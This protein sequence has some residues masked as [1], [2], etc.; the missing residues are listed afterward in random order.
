MRNTVKAACA[1]IAA[2]TLSSTNSADAADLLKVKMSRLAFPSLSTMMIDIV[3][4][5]GIDKRH[6]I[7]LE[8][9]TF[10]GISG[11]YG[12]LANGDADMTASGPLVVQ[13]MILE[14]VPIRIGMTWARMNILSVITGDPSINSIHDLKGKSI[15]ADM[16][17]AEYQTLAVYGRTQNIV[18]GKD[19]TVVQAS[20]PV[21]RGQLEAKRVEAAMM[22]EPT[23]TLALRDHPEYRVILAGDKAWS[24]I[25]KTIGWDLVVAMRE[26]F[27]KSHADAV[28]RLISMFQEGREW[29][30]AHLDEADQ[31]LVD[32]IKLPK[33]AFKAAISSGRLAYEIKPAWESEREAIWNMFKVAVDAGYLPKLPNETVIYKP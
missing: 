28:P 30:M 17:S 32:S 4:A 18:F 13:K 22:W 1:V 6:G 24:A 2:I 26:D 23:T 11:Y 15:A 31:I 14:G 21:A 9:V 33:G 19:I 5:K 10:S 12:A 20:P 29:Y 3:K 8:G 16:G 27:L 25:S 7:D